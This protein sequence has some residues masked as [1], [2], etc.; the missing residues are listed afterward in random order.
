M[1]TILFVIF[2]LTG[3]FDLDYPWC[4]FAVFPFIVSFDCISI[5]ILIHAFLGFFKRKKG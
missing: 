5:S 2:R 3:L 1:G 4:D